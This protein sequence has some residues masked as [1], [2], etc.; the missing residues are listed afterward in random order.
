MNFL[1]TKSS[2]SEQTNTTASTA[3][4]AACGM[5]GPPT[6]SFTCPGTEASVPSNDRTGFITGVLRVNGALPGLID[7]EDGEALTEGVGEICKK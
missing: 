2:A 1:S 4:I 5:V 3:M 7:I 6:S